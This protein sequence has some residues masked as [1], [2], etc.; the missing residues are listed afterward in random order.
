VLRE[1]RDELFQRRVREP[2]LVVEVDGSE[3]AV[4]DGVV[5]VLNRFEGL[6]QSGPDVAALCSDVV[7]PSALGNPE[8]LVE[9]AVA[10]NLFEEV[11][12]RLLVVAGELLGDFPR[13]LLEPVV[14]SL[15]EEQTEDV[16]LVVRRV[17]TTT[18]NIG[19]LPEVRFQRVEFESLPVLSILEEALVFRS[20]T[21]T[22]FHEPFISFWCYWKSLLSLPLEV[23]LHSPPTECG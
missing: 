16:V 20:H 1:V 22:I 14:D 15:Q 7:P 5:L 17:D 18:E 8:L 21:V 3:D 6:V 12:I 9:V 11:F 2:V 23:Q 4:G 19:R 10:S 13:L